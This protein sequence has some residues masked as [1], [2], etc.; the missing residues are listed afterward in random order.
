MPATDAAERRQIAQIAAL[1]RSVTEDGRERIRLAQQAYR[2]SFKIRH[3][4]PMCG[5]IEIPQ[6]LPADEISRRGKA[7]HRVHMQRLA[8]RRDQ[9]RRTAA[10]A[11]ADAEAAE[12]ELADIAAS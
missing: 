2:D 5:V 11:T 12:H 1:T 8:L 6:D 7:A 4:C 9:S 10:A 3:E